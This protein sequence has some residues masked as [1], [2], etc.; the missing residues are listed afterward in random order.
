MLDHAF[1]D[2]ILTKSQ[3]LFLFL[4]PSL[5]DLSELQHVSNSPYYSVFPAVVGLHNC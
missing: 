1:P 3:A 4:A 5:T 2:H